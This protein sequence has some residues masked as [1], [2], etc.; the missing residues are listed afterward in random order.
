MRAW[1]ATLALMLAGCQSGLADA[2]DLPAPDEAYFRCNVQPIVTKSCSMFL[3]HGDTARYFTVFAR[4][5]LRFGVDERNA[6][7]V[8]P[9]WRFDYDATRAQIDREEPEKSLL[10]MKPLDESAGGYYHGGAVEFGQGDVF[11]SA[12]EEDYQTL[13]AWVNG[14]TS[15]ADCGP[16]GGMP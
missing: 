8:E 15:P 10:L 5:R 2:E 1:I 9:E 13:V 16:S 11:L 14:A 7:M 4:N 6:E 3:C 12:E